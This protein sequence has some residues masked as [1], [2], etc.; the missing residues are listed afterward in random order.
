MKTLGLIGF[1]NMGEALVKGASAAVPGLR[2]LVS[3][4]DPVKRDRAV[5]VYGAADRTESM[6]G[7]FAESDAVI[8]AVKPQDLPS[9]VKKIG[10]HAAGKR[11]ISV[12][13]GKTTAFVM[14]STG[15]A[16]VARFMPNL[17]AGV[18]KAVV[19]VCYSDSA[20]DEFRRESLEIAGGLGTAVVL[21]ERLMPAVTG[22]SG[23]GIAFALQFLHAMAL[24]GTKT[25]IPY[26]TSLSI[27]LG[28]A[29]GAAALV[30]ETGSNPVDLVS[31]VC[32][33][34]GT[35]IEGIYELERG[36]FTPAVIAA[37]EAAA[38]RSSE[39]EQ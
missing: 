13:A 24:G 12:L 31:R 23:S 30:R 15:A 22:V 21:P 38:E 36:G 32:S 8:L 1:G 28:V 14:E 9:L 3:E 33:P 34:A 37:V 4:S 7:L 16:Q 26:D 2:F 5:G 6:R 39:L 25:G 35:T 19:G 18:S 11:I 29:E 10:P 20:D 17:A 27:A